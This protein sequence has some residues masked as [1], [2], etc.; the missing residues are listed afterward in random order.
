MRGRGRL[1]Q[2]QAGLL[3]I[4]VIAIA[5]YFSF[6]K[7]IPF[8]GPFQLK[9]VFA[10]AENINVNSPSGSPASMSAR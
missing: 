5:T 2:L 8:T 3:A 4:V 10:D 1:T 9:A 6:A 7:D